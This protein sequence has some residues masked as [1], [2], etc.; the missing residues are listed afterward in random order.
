MAYTVLEKDGYLHVEWHGMLEA[1]D[2]ENLRREIPQRAMKLGRA[3]NLLHTF[4]K[5]TGSNLAPMAAY[6]H[7]IK[8]KATPMPGRSK[9]ATV[10]HNEDV[11]KYAKLVQ[12]LNRNPNLEIEIFQDKEEA[13]VWLRS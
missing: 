7:S 8:R 5:S 6:D 11:Y 2:L 12:E 9:S 3:P 4:E 13:L 10:A 1:E